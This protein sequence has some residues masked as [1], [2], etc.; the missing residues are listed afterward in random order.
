MNKFLTD[1]LTARYP[2]LFRNLPIEVGNGWYN[3]LEECCA[4]IMAAKPS[5]SLQ[6]AQVKEKFGGLRL[7]LSTAGESDEVNKAIFEAVDAAEC[8]SFKTC[9]RCGRP[10]SPGNGSWRRTLCDQCNK[11]TT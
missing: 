1:Q 3:L 2:Q 5:E 10:G 8:A 9:E 6:A 11:G 7:Y 4:R